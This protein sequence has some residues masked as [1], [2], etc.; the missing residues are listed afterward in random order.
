MS[1][2]NLTTTKADIIAARSGP[3][4]VHFVAA[5]HLNQQAKLTSS[6]LHTKMGSVLSL[7]LDQPMQNFH[8]V[9]YDLHF[10]PNVSKT[11]RF[12][13]W[14]PKLKLLGPQAK[15]NMEEFTAVPTFSRT[16]GQKTKTNKDRSRSRLRMRNS[17]SS[18]KSGWK[19]EDA[20]GDKDDVLDIRCVEL[21]LENKK[22]EEKEKTGDANANENGIVMD[23]K[24][25][26]SL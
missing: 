14:A 10:Y 11:Y 12:G 13:I 20:S 24:T 2:I 15:S 1:L 18:P 9:Y 16:R 4:Q 26:Y 17:N 19:D 5:L 22:E 3:G 21:P 23:E 25:L 7:L 8:Q 6:K